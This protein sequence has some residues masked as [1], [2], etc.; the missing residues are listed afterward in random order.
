MKA[1]L[2]SLVD[3]H[4]HLDNAQFRD[5]REAV[6]AR[7]LEQGVT[8][9]LTVGTDLA[10]SRLSIEIASAHPEVYAAVGIHPHDALTAS[11]E[12]LEQLRELITSAPKVVAVGEIGLD[13]Y[14]DRA[15]REAQREAFRRQIR[16]ARE[17]DLPLIVHDRD[18][19]QEVLQILR[20]ENAQEIGGVLHCFSGDLEMA[21]Q[22][23]ELGFYLSFP[24][25]ITYPKN[26]ELRQVVRGVPI[27]RLLVETDC[28]Y[29]APQ[30]FRGRRNEPA[31]VRHT[32]EAIAAIKGLTIADVARITTVNSYR[33]F[34][35]GEAEIDTRIAYPIRRSLYLNITNRCTNACTFC[36]KFRDFTVKGHQLQ[37]A[38]EPTAAEVKAAIGNPQEWQEVVF[39]GYGEPL[40][41]IELVREIAGWLKTL[42]VRVR[43]NTD[44]QANL[45]HGRNVLPEL[46][47]L[48]DSISVSLNAPD[49]ATYQRLC[50]SSFGED[51]YPAVREFLREA[52]KHIPTVTATAVAIPG[53]DMQGCRQVAQELG[54][55]FREREYNEVG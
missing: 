20:E 17:V 38:Q 1:Q 2:P 51:G 29:L 13:F 22:C 50:Q 31:Y 3:T 30:P 26:E 55:E 8:R 28:P 37:L 23:L 27:D 6:I 36:T 10:S 54:V 16:L 21:R 39:C 42:G 53:I 40:I 11:E 45:V 47:G 12:T 5:D 18:A 9:L 34:G 32:A 14:R 48:I 44:G 35:V 15:P 24:G 25:T 43:V 19:H 33:L 4:A 52:K 41:R 49:A 46:S 7:A